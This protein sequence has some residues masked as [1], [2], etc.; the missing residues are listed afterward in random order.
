L[1]VLLLLLVRVAAC[2]LPVYNDVH[3]LY[4]LSVLNFYL[5]ASGSLALPQVNSVRLAEN[6]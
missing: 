5:A 3:T 2:A 4:A 6:G 1:V